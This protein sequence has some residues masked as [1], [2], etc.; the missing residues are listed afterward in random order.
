MKQIK[1]DNNHCHTTTNLINTNI[2]EENDHWINILNDIESEA[3]IIILNLSKSNKAGSK[4]LLKQLKEIYM[5]VKYLLRQI[6][7]RSIIF[8]EL[9]NNQK[10]LA[11]D[12]LYTDHIATRNQFNFLINSYGKL[13]RI[14]TQ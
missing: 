13:K 10:I 5:T 2:K 4:E 1:N 8:N 3:R 9:P 11:S 7:N 14:I 12:L 6:H